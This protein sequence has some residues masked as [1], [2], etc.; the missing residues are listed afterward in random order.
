MTLPYLYILK[1]Y[2]NRIIFVSTIT[3]FTT[4][5]KTPA[6]FLY[7]IVFSLCNCIY[8]SRDTY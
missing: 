2:T 6:F 8:G 4:K 5:V 1:G 3:L 7:P